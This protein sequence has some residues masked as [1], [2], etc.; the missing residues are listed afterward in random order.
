[1][2]LHKRLLRNEVVR[3]VLCAAAAWYVRLA[4]ATGRW[5]VEGGDVPATFWREGR[6][7]IIAFWHGR[8]LMMPYCWD[9]SAAVNMLI[10]EHPDGQFIARIVGHF[11][12]GTI[13]GSTRR[14]GASA[15][16]AM[17]RALKSGDCVGITP[18]GPRGPR[19]RAGGAIVEVGR[20]AR[21][22]VVPVA[23]ATSRRRVLGTWDRFVVALPL[24]RGVFVWGQPISV[25]PDADAETREAA[26]RA[27]EDA[28]N[29]VTREADRLVGQP[30]IEPAAEVAPAGPGVS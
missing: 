21:V 19:M 14:G 27:L 12:Y 10:S 9:N 6:P 23:F 20:L 17:L 5:R 28:L 11:G 3:G 25:A 7:F 2:K 18:D 8:L 24:S 1:M 4:Y 29:A 22:P 16:R 15:L 30:A 26:R 13:A